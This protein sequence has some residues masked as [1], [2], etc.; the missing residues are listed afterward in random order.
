MLTYVLGVKAFK[1]KN[2]QNQYCNDI[3][4]TLDDL[5]PYSHHL[6]FLTSYKWVKKLEFFSLASVSRGV[7]HNTLAYLA[8]V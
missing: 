6:I 2:R 7:Q 1:Y 8:N 4:Q 5:G 3:R